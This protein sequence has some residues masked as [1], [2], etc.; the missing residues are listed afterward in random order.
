[1]DV[2]SNNLLR[3]KFMKRS[4][5]AERRR[6]LEDV[7]HDSPLQA[8][9]PASHTRTYS[10][11]LTGAPAGRGAGTLAAR[12]RLKFDRRPRRRRGCLGCIRC[13]SAASCH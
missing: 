12:R 1:M 2:F 7:P 3:M 10:L 11:F 9:Q 8:I 5:E 6:Q 4:E 13:C